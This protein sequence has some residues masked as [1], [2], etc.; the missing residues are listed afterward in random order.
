MKDKKGRIKE[1][2]DLLAG[3]T[4]F[5]LL[6][7]ISLR[8]KVARGFNDVRIIPTPRCTVVHAQQATIIQMIASSMIVVDDDIIMMA[9]DC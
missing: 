3:L 5:K 6:K 8:V 7:H 9:D 2:I 4:N 1:I